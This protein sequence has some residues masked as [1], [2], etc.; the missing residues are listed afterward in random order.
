M[1]QNS[2]T[3]ASEG[4]STSEGVM[5]SKEYQ[6]VTEVSGPL[7]IVDSVSD[8]A[9]G[10]VVRIRIPDGQERLGQVLEAQTDKA[11]VQVFEGTKGLDTKRLVSDSL[12]RP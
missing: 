10:E 8:V 3:Q 11:V 9:Y 1:T 6:T 12:A 7:M 5:K 4:K 2:S